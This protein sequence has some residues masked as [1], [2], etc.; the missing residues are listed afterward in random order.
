MRVDNQL[1]LELSNLS[2]GVSKAAKLFAKDDP[3]DAFAKLLIGDDTIIGSEFDDP[4][5]WGGKGNDLLWGRGGFDILDGFKGNDVN[6]GGEGNDQLI[7]TKGD[8]TFQFS[9]P[10]QV[11]AANF[12][13][14]FDTI[15]KLG[16]SDE[17]YLKYQY[18]D[19][20]GM[21][22][23]KG[24]LA[25]SDQAQDSNDYFLFFNRTFWYDPDANGPGQA[26]P[27]FQTE[28]GAKLTHKMIE[29]GVSGDL[30]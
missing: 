17:I 1:G 12:N 10:F 30:Y 29:L 16:G 28:N 25:F 27:I 18:F 13:F 21:R 7:D 14:N 6:D 3:L 11:G 5:I 26:T 20:A 24:E 2:L 15:K 8:D 4:N 23:S 19:A 9:T 22:V